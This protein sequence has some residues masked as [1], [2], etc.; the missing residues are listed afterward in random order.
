MN[1]ERTRVVRARERGDYE[2][3]PDI[4]TLKRVLRD[5]RQ[6]AVEMGGLLIKLGQFLGARADLLPPEA[7][8]E[9]AALQDEVRPEPFSAIA[10]VIVEEFHAPASEVFA[11]VDEAPTGSASLGQVH[12]ARLHDGR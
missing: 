9:L 1:R 6:T 10:E 12:R 8:A 7:L 5:F 2:T 3:R 11:S 4:E